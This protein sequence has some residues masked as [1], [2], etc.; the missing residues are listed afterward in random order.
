MDFNGSNDGLNDSFDEV[1]EQFSGFIEGIKKNPLPVILVVIIAALIVY[2]IIGSVTAPPAEED[3]TPVIINGS[4]VAGRITIQ[5][6][7]QVISD[8]QLDGDILRLAPDEN[9]NISMDISVPG[10]RNLIPRTVTLTSGNRRVIVTIDP[11]LTEIDDNG[12]IHYHFENDGNTGNGQIIVDTNTGQVIVVIDPNT[13]GIIECDEGTIQPDGTCVINVEIDLEDPDTGEDITITIPVIPVTGTVHTESEVTQGCLNMSTGLVNELPSTGIVKSEIR[14]RKVCAEAT[15]INASI[16]WVNERMGNVEVVL[17]NV[18]EILTSQPKKAA[19]FS[20][21]DTITAKINF[22]PFKEY[23]GKTANFRINL[24]T[25]GQASQIGFVI[26]IENLEQCV[27]ITP[28]KVTVAKEQNSASFE[29]DASSCGQNNIDF[30][31]CEGDN[32]CAGGVEGGIGLSSKTFTLNS[33]NNPKR[34]I[35]VTRGAIPGAYGITIRASVGGSKKIYLGEVLA[36]IERTGTETLYPDKYVISLLPG[37]KDSIRVTNT[38]L[39]QTVNLSTS[40]CTLYEKS[41]GTGGNSWWKQLSGKLKDLAGEGVYEEALSYELGTLDKVTE[42][43]RAMATLKNQLIK[44]AWVA[45]DRQKVKE[46]VCEAQSTAFDAYKDMNKLEFMVNEAGAVD[47]TCGAQEEQAFEEEVYDFDIEACNDEEKIDYLAS[48][49]ASKITDINK[50]VPEMKTELDEMKTSVND[51]NIKDCE[52]ASALSSKK[53]SAVS[54]ITTAKTK[55]DEYAAKVNSARKTMIDFNKKH[56]ETDEFF[57]AF[58]A[59][60]ELAM[61]KIQSAQDLLDQANTAVDYAIAD[62]DSALAAA[63]IDATYLASSDDAAAATYLEQAIID[64]SDANALIYMAIEEEVAA[65]DILKEFKPKMAQQYARITAMIDLIAKLKQEMQEAKAIA[66]QIKTSMESAKTDVQSIATAAQNTC[67]NHDSS[68]DYDGNSQTPENGGCCRIASDAQ[69]VAD[70][71]ETS[72]VQEQIQAIEEVV[73]K[74]DLLNTAV[75]LYE[76]KTKAYGEQLPKTQATVQKAVDALKVMTDN[77]IFQPPM[78]TLQ[79]AIDAANWLSDKESASSAAS[80]YPNGLMTFNGQTID[81]QIMSGLFAT[82]VSSGFIQGAYDGKVYTKEYDTNEDEEIIEEEIVDEEYDPFLDETLDEEPTSDEALDDSFNEEFEEEFVCSEP[83]YTEWY[84][85]CDNMVGLLLPDFRIN[86]LNA[87]SNISVSNSAIRAQFNPNPADAKVFGVFDSQEVGASFNSTP[88]NNNTYAIVT[89]NAQASEHDDPTVIDSEFS[90]FSIPDSHQTPVSYKYHFKFNATPRKAAIFQPK[91]N[92]CQSGIL[93]GTNSENGLAK[94]ILTWG[95]SDIT[96]LDSGT[97]NLGDKYFDATQLSIIINGR[98]QRLQN[99]LSTSTFRCPSNPARAE[100]TSVIPDF[101]PEELEEAGRSGLTLGT[102]ACYLPYTT[103]ELDGKPSLY[104]FLLADQAKADNLVKLVNFKANLSR[105][106][107]GTTFQNEF[108]NYYKTQTVSANPGF[109]DAQTGSS[110]YFSNNTLA[111][112][113]SEGTNYTKNSSFVL[114]DAGEYNIKL[115]INFNGQ[116]TLY[117]S[118]NPAAKIVFDLYST[119]PIYSNY[120]PFYYTP[121]D[122]QVGL[123]NGQTAEGYRTKLADAKTIVVNSAQGAILNNI[124]AQALVSAQ[125]TVAEQ[126]DQL[127]TSL[128]LRGK[129]LSLSNPTL[130]NG[131]GLYLSPNIYY[132]QTTATPIILGTPKNAIPHSARYMIKNDLTALAYPSTSFALFKPLNDTDSSRNTLNTMMRIPDKKLVSNT[133][134]ID[135]PTS[136]EPNEWK[137]GTVIYTLSGRP[138]Y[139]AG[140]NQT[141]V[142]SP[143]NTL[144]TD[145]L[146]SLYGVP[147]MKYNDATTTQLNSLSLLYDAVKQGRACISRNANDDI[148]YWPEDKILATLP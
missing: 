81:N 100:L 125:P 113:A 95:W 16:E 2:I 146:V 48:L 34:T 138:Y 39:I 67:D 83:P 36:I 90:P 62:Y 79:P 129:I 10:R 60:V 104:Y 87:S 27:K 143:N 77:N 118:S 76:Q 9:G 8:T 93:R 55:L 122:G 44:D 22:V 89:I 127:N 51:L 135:L 88:L 142:Y 75:K 126:L 58:D 28:Q 32:G 35:T 85:D 98:M 144:G 140:M 59:N 94:N 40:V 37:S 15:D 84:E 106:G 73:P 12:N 56:E 132:A 20:S 19:Q 111:Y 124:P 54:Q 114:P 80:E 69:A 49:V 64:L 145:P 107:Y 13:G 17:N 139:V 137:L 66:Q 23:E 105:D 96:S 14:L 119:N 108:T 103:R 97:E 71:I 102:P 18:S 136:N 5:K 128:T 24:T 134:S 116:P 1:G 82:A 33:S 130:A 70:S 115:R 29:I 30:S 91:I 26:P 99:L 109:L 101:T 65:N 112:Y 141:K 148:F 43:M 6:D 46:K 68:T 47:K 147:S 53:S 42:Q 38:E 92:D 50:V 41:L 61:E 11:N 86:L 52:S 45:F 31:L 123:A 117:T 25:G 63:A 74:I 21:T 110:K 133:Y 120:S 57:E 7:G 72:S 4:G 3:N 121:L 131:T 78:D